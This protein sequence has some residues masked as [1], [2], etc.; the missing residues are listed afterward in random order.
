MKM[1]YQPATERWYVYCPHMAKADGVEV[2]EVEDAKPLDESV[3][4][5]S[6]V[7][8]EEPPVSKKRGGRK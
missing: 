6:P 4:P 2:V 8:V 7:V 1:L 3:I 5:E